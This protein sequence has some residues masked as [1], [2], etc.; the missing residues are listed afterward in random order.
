LLSKQDESD[1]NENEND[2]LKNENENQIIT[3]IKSDQADEE[4]KI[5]LHENLTLE[6]PFLEV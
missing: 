1:K 2:Q 3:N 6:E 4:Q 5:S